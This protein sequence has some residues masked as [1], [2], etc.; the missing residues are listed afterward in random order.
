MNNHLSF[1][2]CVLFGLFEIGL[3]NAHESDHDKVIERLGKGN[4]A[5]ATRD[6]CV[7]PIITSEGL[8]LKQSGENVWTLSGKL[9][10]KAET[11]V[12][13]PEDGQWDF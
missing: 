8:S 4:S 3:S 7:N 11:I 12:L 6:V 1:A 10:A 13:R 2:C 9:K 5:G